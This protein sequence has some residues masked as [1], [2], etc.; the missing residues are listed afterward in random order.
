[1][2][3]NF[4]SLS[5]DATAP[6]ADV[7]PPISQQGSIPSPA[8]RGLSSHVRQLSKRNQGILRWIALA[9]V[10]GG[11]VALAFVQRAIR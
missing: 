1:M 5:D 4:G 11:V 2:R 8:A 7:V 9:V 6:L 3:R 10:A